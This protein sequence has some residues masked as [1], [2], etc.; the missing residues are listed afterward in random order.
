MQ[1]EAR[2]RA[3]AAVAR[4]GS[5][6][7]AADELYVS[8]PAVSKQLAQ[9]ERELGRDLVTR[10]REGA[11]LTPAGEI[12][13]DFVLRAEALLANAAR[14]LAAD[15]GAETGVLQIAASATPSTYLLPALLARFRER[16]PGVQLSSEPA[17]S[18]DALEL[19]RA[20]GVE[21]AVVGAVERPARARGRTARRRRDRARRAAGARRPEASA[22]GTWTGSPGYRS[23]ARPPVSRSMRRGARWASTERRASSCTRPRRSSVSSPAVPASPRSAGSRSTLSSPPAA[24]RSSTCRAGGCRARSR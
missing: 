17:T 20:H 9:L 22:R 10:G 14:A 23:R 24:S 7:R 15:A 21:L 18:L 6:S 1:L 8:Q 3:F 13:A 2:L 16:H 19:V 12:L 5:V 11:V 4:C